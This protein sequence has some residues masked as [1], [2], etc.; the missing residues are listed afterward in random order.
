MRMYC[1]ALQRMRYKRSWLKQLVANLLCNQG[2]GGSNP[3]AGTN[4]FPI[5]QVLLCVASDVPVSRGTPL[6]Q[7][8]AKLV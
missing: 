3:S 4:K 8:R 6:A 2:V 7:S 5:N 1:V